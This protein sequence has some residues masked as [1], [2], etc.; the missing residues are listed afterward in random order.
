MLIVLLNKNL[1]GRRKKR[2]KSEIIDKD[3]VDD[4]VKIF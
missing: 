1:I 4:V 3:G 2:V